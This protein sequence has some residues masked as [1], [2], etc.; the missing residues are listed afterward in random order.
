MCVSEWGLAFFG[1]TEM[2]MEEE[3]E[4]GA[5][6]IRVA[7]P[8]DV[9]YVYAI[10][11]EMERSAR[12]RGTG[13][14][15]R[16]PQTL[17][18]KIYERKAVIA[19]TAAGDWAGFSYIEV[20]SGGKFVSNS[21]LIVNPEYRNA[22]VATAIKREVF[23]L[24]RRLYPS[25]KIFSITTG[26]AILKMNSRLD[27]EPVTYDQITQDERFWDQCK[28]CVNF[29]ILQSQGRKRCLCTAML[30]RPEKENGTKKGQLAAGM[31]MI[32]RS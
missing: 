3:P 14:A 8:A 29:G 22:G 26:A 31:D 32:V 23:A 17:C 18:Q 11:E 1:K 19:V 7:A 20:Y 25:A 15:K 12:A 16:K 30:F 27:F 13:I 24:A 28:A 6:S 9:K 2:I 10:L 5:I 21:G 4:G